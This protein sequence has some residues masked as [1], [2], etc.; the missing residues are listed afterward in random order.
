MT[1]T[2]QALIEKLEAARDGGRELDAE[3][4]RECGIDWSPDEGG[5]YGPYGIM[6]ARVHFT[7]SLDAALTLLLPGWR[8]ER[9]HQGI[10]GSTATLTPYADGPTV[11]GYSLADGAA[12][13][14]IAICIAA[15]KAREAGN[16]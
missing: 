12:S 6:P 2:T 15:L 14:R 9:L 5:N 11:T 7:R 3:I 8:L 13:L 16:G 4:A 10:D 1:P